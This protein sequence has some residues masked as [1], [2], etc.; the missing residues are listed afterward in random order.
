M[1][2]R[3]PCNEP[4]KKILKCGHPCI[5]LC[6]EKCPSKC[7]I[8]N[9]DEVCE[10]F[11][12]N[13]DE[14][15]ARFIEFEECQHLIEV[16]ACDAWITQDLVADESKS[17]KVQFKT[18]PKCKTQ[19]RK[20]LRYGNIIKKTLE[21]YENIKAKQLISLTNYN[22]IIEKFKR[23]KAEIPED[24][25]T[26]R[27]SSF[28]PNFGRPRLGREPRIKPSK[29]DIAF[30]L[31]FFQPILRSLQDIG[32]KIEPPSSSQAK[33]EII[34]PP[35]TVNNINVQLS[36]LEYLLRII[37][38]LKALKSTTASGLLADTDIIDNAFKDIHKDILEVLN[39]LMQDFL[40]DQQVADI[41]SEIYR[42]MSLIKLLDLWSKL[43]TSEKLQTLSQDDKAE[44]TSRIV[45]LHC[46]E[47]KL[48]E[49]DN[50][51]ILQFITKLSETYQVS[52]LTELER[53]EI[54]KAIGLTKGH[55]FKCPK[56]HYYCIGECGGA[57]EEAK[58]PECGAKIGGQSHRLTEGNELA[59]EMDGAHHAAWS[60][61]ANMGNFDLDHLL[62]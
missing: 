29:E 60:E 5:G 23:V 56:G 6:G 38:Y 49:E 9:R 41:Q 58:C 44:L 47:W 16:S 22:N 39:F 28:I 11:F 61:A 40:S 20:S 25:T 51:E 31:R 14:E 21:D 32:D 8:C 19:I 45:R 4:C 43:K 15:D 59:P 18:C 26:H 30:Y 57:M 62:N 34:L 2:D 35:H 33:V 54:V 42:L 10:I 36:Y 7:R 1:C 24:V 13:E 52:G 50:S 37:K 17:A 12:G 46:S 48:N 53:V 3:E 27:Q 55:W